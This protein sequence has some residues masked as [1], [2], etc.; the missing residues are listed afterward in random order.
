MFQIRAFVDDIETVLIG[1]QEWTTKNLNVSKYRNGDIIPEVKDPKKWANLKTGAWCYYDNDPKNGEIY[2]KLY[3]WYAVNDPRGLAPEG[4]HVPSQNEWQELRS[5]LNIGYPGKNGATADLAGI[6][7]SVNTKPPQWFVS[8]HEKV[9]Y[10]TS[11]DLYHMKNTSKFDS[12][13]AGYRN[14]DGWSFFGIGL[15]VKYWSQEVSKFGIDISGACSIHKA[16]DGELYEY[17]I[18]T[19]KKHGH[20]IRL[21]KDQ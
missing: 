17:G 16:K 11:F 13:F 2:G 10:L 21:L 1:N 5:F 14:Q 9:N 19:T 4:Y 3:N 12:L 8:I 15:N 20:P 6:K 18:E 7:L